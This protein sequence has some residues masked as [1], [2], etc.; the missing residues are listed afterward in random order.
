MNLAI[1][2]Y[3]ELRASDHARIE[4]FRR[5]C[6]PNATRIG[7]HFTLLFPL[8]ADAEILAAEGRAAADSSPPF[9]FGIRRTRVV[10]DAFSTQSHVFLVPDA[11]AA[12][13]EQLHDRLYAGAFAAER[14]ADIPFI[15]HLTVAAAAVAGAAAALA[16]QLDLAAS[17]VH[18]KVRALVLIDVAPHEVRPVATWAL[19]GAGEPSA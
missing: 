18:G 10:G 17:P 5:R 8:D 11:G 2:A 9:A 6:D 14:R 3:P 16:A 1:V 19:G 12:E 7:V 13:I 4:A 15:P